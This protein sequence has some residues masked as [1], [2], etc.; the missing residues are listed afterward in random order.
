MATFLE[1]LSSPF[2]QNKIIKFLEKES[3][4]FIL[5]K[6]LIVGGFKAWLVGFV[7]EEIVE[8]ADEYLIEPAFRKIGFASDYL[9]G[10]RIYKKVSNAQDVDE[11][12]DT[13]G[14]V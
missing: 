10:A 11:W 9:E 1:W 5:K 7:V 14:D 6:L 13:L 8:E 2:I 4:K 12:V 3:S